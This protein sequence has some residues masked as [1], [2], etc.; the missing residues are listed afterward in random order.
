MLSVGRMEK[1][2][3]APVS[4]VQ[5]KCVLYATQRDIKMFVRNSHNKVANMSKLHIPEAVM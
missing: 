3:T 2:V 4:S 1:N 5:T